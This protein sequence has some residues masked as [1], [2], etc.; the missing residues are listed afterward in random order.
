MSMPNLPQAM[1]NAADYRPLIEL[2]DYADAQDLVDFLSDSGFPVGNVRIIG[3]G[4]HTVEQV[5]RRKTNGRAA[6]E[7]A[8]SGAWFGLLLGL[9]LSLFVPGQTWFGMVIAAVVFTALWGALFGFL[10]HW[11]TRGK[12]DFA[13]VKGLE[14]SGYEVQVTAEHLAEARRLAKI[15]AV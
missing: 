5:T 7:G 1:R 15:D 3:T 11:S 2:K 10:A 6:L 8:G 4:L 13:S 9:L 14:A 12:R